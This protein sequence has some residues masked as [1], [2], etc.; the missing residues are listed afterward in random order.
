M[1][2]GVGVSIYPS[3]E[4]KG[5]ATPSTLGTGLTHYWSLDEVSGARADPVGSLALTDVNTVGSAAGINN[6]AATFL[7]ASDQKLTH[8]N[9][10]TFRFSNTTGGTIAFWCKP[11]ALTIGL[12][13]YISVCSAAANDDE[14]VIY[15]S[16]TRLFFDLLG[17]TGNYSDYSE[18]L[19]AIGSLTF[20]D[21][22][23]VI[24]WYDQAAKTANI[25]INDANQATGAALA[26][27]LHFGT[28][29]LVVGYYE[30][31]GNAQTGLMDEVAMWSRVLTAPER[32]ELYNAG[33]GKFYP[34]S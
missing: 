19:T 31:G 6:L 26:G 10:A 32:T 7:Q 18:A 22:N 20:N 15:S 11:S 9:D 1:N 14:Y 27:T 16:G 3:Y 25:S 12:S 28:K 30:S 13:G 5:G 8:V 2:T 24:A 23:L 21:W 17:G 34:F 4:E 29:P 33:A